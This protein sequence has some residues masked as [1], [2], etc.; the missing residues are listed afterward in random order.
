MSS[1]AMGSARR[2]ILWVVGVLL[3]AGI[4]AFGLRYAMRMPAVK[5]KVCGD[6]CGVVYYRR[7]TSEQEQSVSLMATSTVVFIGDSHIRRMAVSAVSPHAENLGI[8]GETARGM[9]KRIKRFAL[10]K[11]CSTVLV[12]VGVNDLIQGMKPSVVAETVEQIVR[13]QLA[14]VRVIL[15]AVLP[16]GVH[17]RSSILLKPAI[18]ILNERVSVH[19]A[20]AI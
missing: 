19:V 11:R 3:M 14:D 18:Q 12:Q 4:A 20:A 8:G 13:N 9:G 16:V 17:A 7:L 5:R 1:A 10:A 6:T 15:T 2:I